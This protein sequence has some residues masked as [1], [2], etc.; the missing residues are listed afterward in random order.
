MGG[1]R[2]TPPRRTLFPGD[3]GP[4]RSRRPN[5][6]AGGSRSVSI[7]GETGDPT[8]I[9]SQR[10]A[11]SPRARQAARSRGLAGPLAAPGPA[12]GTSGGRRGGGWGQMGEGWGGNGGSATWDSGKA[13]H[14]HCNGGAPFNLMRRTHIREGGQQ[15]GGKKEAPHTKSNRVSGARGRCRQAPGCADKDNVHMALAVPLRACIMAVIVGSICA[16]NEGSLSLDAA[17][18]ECRRGPTGRR[19]RA[20]KADTCHYR[21]MCAK[22]ID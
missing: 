4:A 21:Q 19:S 15:K 5:A 3:A 7:R 2:E 16:P 11:A 12:G 10:V 17:R 8:R 22:R 9:K 13:V 20:Q 6:A 14:R 18:R 1:R